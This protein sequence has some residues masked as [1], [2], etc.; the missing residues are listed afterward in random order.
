MITRQIALRCKLLF[1]CLAFCSQGLADEIEAYLFTEIKFNQANYLA[2]H[3]EFINR[4]RNEE[5]AKANAIMLNLVENIR[6]DSTVSKMTFAK[7]LSNSAISNAI[8]GNQALA[9]SEFESA[10]ELLIEAS[11]RYNTKL[12]KIL[13]A[14]SLV[15]RFE[16]DNTQAENALRRTQ[17]IFHRQSG[18]YAEAQLPVVEAL[19]Y[20]NL[21]R[22]KSMAAD[23]EQ[24]FRLKI[25]EEVYGRNSK[26]IIPT[27]ESLGLYFANRASAITANREVESAIYRDKLFKVAI[28]FF[29]RAIAII[30]DKYGTDDLRLISVLHGISKT[31]TIA[32]IKD[33]QGTNDLRLI[34]SL[35]GIS[36]TRFIQ[37][38][39]FATARESMERASQIISDSPTT[40]ITDHV[41]SLIALGDTYLITQDARSNSIYTQAW[42]LLDEVPENQSIRDQFF[43][44]PKLLYPDVLIERILTRQPSNTTPSEDLF[45]DLEYDV[46][47]NGRVRNIQV[48]ESNVPNNEKKLLRNYVS[49]MRY[50]PRLVNGQ[51]VTTEGIKLHQIFKVSV[52]SGAA[53]ELTEQLIQIEQE[54]PNKTPE[55]LSQ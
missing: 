44:Q 21:R 45:V 29:E 34:G 15:H 2:N 54:M 36:K 9:I 8:V 5:H 7:T 46:R 1:A 14:K 30:E 47:Q 38:S 26:E 18:V 13:M 10:I 32:I 22:G 48:I 40:D 49:K 16:K 3:E 17:H 23:R 51:A 50:R 20:M 28:N 41:K 24:F 19:T 39:S 42:N 11:D 43:G 37:G 27:L 25:S 35:H 33:K 55:N 31:R 6:A 53:K 52:Q 4:L 12:T